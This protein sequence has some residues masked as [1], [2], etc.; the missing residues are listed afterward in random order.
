MAHTKPTW[1]SL[2]STHFPLIILLLIS[3]C[4]LTFR[5]TQNPPG[6]F[7][8]EATHGYEAYSILTTGG[9]SSS[10]EFMP[11]YFRKPGSEQRSHPSF[12]YA[13]VPSIALL[14]LT[15]FAVRIVSV[16]SSLILL[17]ALYLFLVRRLS[18]MIALL[19]LMWWPLAGW[20]F[21]LSRDGLEHM[22][23]S[24][25]GFCAWFLIVRFWES[26]SRLKNK[27][28]SAIR[29]SIHTT[30]IGAL[31]LYVFFSHSAGK[32][33]SLGYF[34]LALLVILA[35][36]IRRRRFEYALP[37]AIVFF[38]ITLTVILTLPYIADKTFFYR[39]DELRTLCP[40]REVEC[41]K[42]NLI[43]HINPKTYFVP[44]YLPPDF[45]VY[46]HSIMGTTLIPL[47]LAPFIVL[48]LLDLII[49][50]L[51]RKDR[52][53]LFIAPS[54]LIGMIPASLTIRGFDTWR[55]YALLPFIFILAAYGMNVLWQ[56]LA[57]VEKKY[58]HAAY[59]LL[60]IIMALVIGQ[61]T[62]SLGAAYALETNPEAASYSGW[63]YGYRQIFT[64]I[65]KVGHR[66]DSIRVTPFIAYDAHLHIR[67]FDPKGEWPQITIG[68]ILPPEDPAAQSQKILYV[69]TAGEAANPRFISQHKITYPNG[70]PAFYIGE[71][72]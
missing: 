10:G 19:T 4:I 13:I 59:I 39:A 5:L 23:A 43:T 41:F 57:H 30:A 15:E 3:A 63:Q 37:G 36:Y 33:L 49:R 64:Y 71:V 55:S 70:Q 60:P 56:G 22:F 35:V 2:L 58:S 14:G 65:T 20:V 29:L 21:F 9:Y 32:V 17:T 6:F 40:G 18:P 62:H 24:M 16:F 31:C 25:L 66:Y 68:E 45:P 53:L 7:V 67:F 52:L 54:F 48:G 1:Q 69:V 28:P 51:K 38:F 50:L 46:R 26:E 8:D 42:N 27:A 44:T 34:A 61:A 72:R 12:I 47:I 11:R